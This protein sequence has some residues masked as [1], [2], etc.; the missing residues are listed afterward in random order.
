MLKNELFE[1]AKR[2]M[3]LEEESKERREYNPNTMK[4]IEAYKN[5]DMEIE[6][7][8]MTQAEEFMKN[9]N[10]SEKSTLS[11]VLTV[12]KMILLPEEFLRMYL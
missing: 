8:A 3:Y 2:K 9:R 10:L 7:L 5:M 6:K 1:E 11:Q 4:I 12:Y